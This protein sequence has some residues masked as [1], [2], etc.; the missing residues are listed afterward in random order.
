ML[1]GSGAKSSQPRQNAGYTWVGSEIAGGIAGAE[2]AEV[3][4]MAHR[5][6]LR[7]GTPALPKSAKKN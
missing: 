1:R 3:G 5:V 2:L 7:R 6:E 4:G